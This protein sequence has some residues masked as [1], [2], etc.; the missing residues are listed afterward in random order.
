LENLDLDMRIILKWILKGMR[1]FVLDGCDSGWVQAAGLNSQEGP[2]SVE[3]V[4]AYCY[5]HT[6][7]SA[8][9][10]LAQL[11]SFT[12]PLLRSPALIMFEVMK[13]F[14]LKQVTHHATRA[15]TGLCTFC[16]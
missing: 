7:P 14:S 12:S 4:G 8:I 16:H 3:V 5:V 1:K 13:G 2:C 11:P 10:P 15:H 9:R 6:R